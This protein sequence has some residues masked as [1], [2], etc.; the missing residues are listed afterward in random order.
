[1]SLENDAIITYT[2]GTTGRPKGA[3]LTRAQSLASPTASRPDSVRGPK[4]RREGQPGQ[5]GLDRHGVSANAPHG[6][7]PTSVQ[8]TLRSTEVEQDAAAVRGHVAAG[9]AC[10]GVPDDSTDRQ[11]RRG[12]G[13][14]LR[15]AWY[16]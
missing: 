8:S 6:R 14:L 12:A 7:W 9:V 1:M 15:P 11:A 2:S 3:Q 13:V 10:G 16:A 4:Q 5:P